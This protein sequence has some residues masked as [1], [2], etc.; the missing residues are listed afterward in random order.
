MSCNVYVPSWNATGAGILRRQRIVSPVVVFGTLLY[1]VK[2]PL[3]E[4]KMSVR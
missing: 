3:P 2:D 4:P 1:T